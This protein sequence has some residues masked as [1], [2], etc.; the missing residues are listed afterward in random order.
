[1][2]HFS[3][4]PLLVLL[5]VFFCRSFL[6]CNTFRSEKYGGR[7]QHG[8]SPT[9][10][11]QHAL[12]KSSELKTQ[13][14]TKKKQNNKQKETNWDQTLCYS[15][16]KRAGLLTCTIKASFAKRK[17]SSL[18]LGGQKVERVCFRSVL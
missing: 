2:Y 4:T 18:F 5:F 10:V 14:K 1:M 15:W 7:E 13:N 8:N 3:H 16:E 11:Q 6:V 12:E 17:S 9:T